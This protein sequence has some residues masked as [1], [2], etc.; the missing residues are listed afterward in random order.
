MAGSR[1]PEE[2]ATVSGIC[3]IL[4]AF[5]PEVCRCRDAVGALDGERLLINSHH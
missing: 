3:G 1:L 5:Y 4:P 2:C